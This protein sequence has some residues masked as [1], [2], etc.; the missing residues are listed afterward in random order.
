MGL[1]SLSSYLKS[2]LLPLLLRLTPVIILLKSCSN[3]STHVFFV[4]LDT[5]E[6]FSLISIQLDV[7]FHYEVNCSDCLLVRRV[8]SFCVQSSED[9]P[10][11]LVSVTIIRVNCPVIT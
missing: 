8:N 11:P 9:V 1:I 5:V 4:D 2:T 3:C 10:L 6:Y 7:Y